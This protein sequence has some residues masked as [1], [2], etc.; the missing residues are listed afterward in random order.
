[1]LV[2]YR[3]GEV[4]PELIFAAVVRLLGLDAE[5]RSTPQP[6]VTR[7]LRDILGSA[8]RMV[9]DRTG[10]LIDLWSAALILLAAVG[11]KKV[12]VQGLRAFPAGLTLVWWGVASL[13]GGR[14]S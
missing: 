3:E 4:Q 7:E 9:Y 6:V 10:G 12:L 11:I 8:N 2:V 1:M 13:L 5:L 14:Q